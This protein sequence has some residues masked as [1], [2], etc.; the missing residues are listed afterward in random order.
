MIAVDIWGWRPRPHRYGHAAAVGTAGCSARYFPSITLMSGNSETGEQA[1]LCGGRAASA[2]CKHVLQ[3]GRMRAL[4]ILCGGEQYGLGP[5][6]PRLQILQ[7]F[8]PR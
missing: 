5:N 2:A 4:E 6:D 3:H 8:T 7:R 1:R